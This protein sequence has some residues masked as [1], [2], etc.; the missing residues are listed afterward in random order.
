[1][2]GILE[3]RGGNADAKNPRTSVLVRCAPLSDRR[4]G[5]A[6][7]L[8]SRLARLRGQAAEQRARHRRRAR[9]P[10]LVLARF[11]FAADRSAL[12]AHNRAVA[13]PAAA[14]RRRVAACA[15]R[16]HRHRLEIFPP[17]RRQAHLQ[18]GR[19]RHRCAA[20]EP[21]WRVDLAW[22]V[23]FHRMVCGAPRLLRHPGAARRPPLRRRHLLSRQPR[24]AARRPR[25]V[26]GRSA[27]H[28]AAPA[29]E[30]L[31]LDLRVLHDLGPAHHARLAPRPLHLRAVGGRLRALARVLHADAAGALPRA[32]RAVALHPP[33]RP[34]PSRRAVQLD[35]SRPRPRPH[36]IARSFAMSHLSV[37]LKAGVAVTAILAQLV[38]PAGP[39]AAFCGFYVAK[40]D[41][42]LFNKSSKVVLAR[43]GQTT[44]I[45]MASDYEGEPKEFAVVIPVPTFI[46]RKQIGVVDM[47]TID[48]LDAFTAPRLVEYFDGDPCAPPPPAMAVASR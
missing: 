8:Q 38:T 48:H 24:G 7:D 3:I 27:C 39:A 47:K 17:D 36:C 33:A 32:D 1:M 5:D 40:A 16:R 30:R 21:G 45:T 26:A 4:P 42:K 25:A 22:P 9:H 6:S 29:A 43:N 34:D 11:R 2:A 41:A 15:R 46:E 35:R 19:L 12:A 37:R 13:Q 31:A 28:P 20:G 10:G 23:G 14:R 44:A 18:S